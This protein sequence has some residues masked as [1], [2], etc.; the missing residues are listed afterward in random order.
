MRAS[1]ALLLPLLALSG[2][3]A[4]TGCSSDRMPPPRDQL[5]PED[6]WSRIPPSKEWLYATS[7][8][9]GP[10]KEECDH[11]FGW[12]KGEAACKAS[13]CEHGRELAEEWKTRCSSLEEPNVVDQTRQI[14]ADLAARAA[15][16]PTECGKRLEAIVR[17]GCGEDTTC[18]VT[19]QHWA[20]RCAKSEGTPMVM[21]ILQ[22]FLER[23]QEPGSGP[24]A[25]D[26]RTCD[27]LHA[28]VVA[29]GKCKDRFVCQEA[30]PGVETYRDRCESESE[31]PTIATAVTELTVLVGGGK[32]IKLIKVRAGSP[33]LKPADVPVTLGDGSGGV[34]Y[35]CEERAT[36]L[37][38]YLGSRKSCQ[39]G[40]MV[41]ARAFSTPRGVEVRVGTLDFPD[42]AWF[43]TRY[44]TILASGEVE[45][46]DKEAAGALA[47][48]LDK[49]AELAKSSG[50]VAEATRVLEKAVLTH[51]LAIKRSPALREVLA[52]RDE[53]FVPVLK[54]IARAKLATS[55]VRKL[56]P[57]DAAG[58]LERAKTRAFADL[59]EGGAVQIGAPGRGFTLQ[60]TVLLPRAMEA[61]LAV[62]KPAKIRKLDAK[63]VAA[64]KALGITAA[65]ACG[66]WEKKLQ[67]TKKSLVS[68]N[69]DLETCDEARHTAL[70]KSVDEARVA[71]ESAFH[72]LEAA[73]TTDV[74][75]TVALG[76]AADAA[77]CREP[78]W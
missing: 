73:R 8:F 31:L 72:D 30:I 15:E 4:L 25:L 78:W 55:K 2:L 46:R 50:G 13:L 42:D 65:Q 26:P 12:V 39:G 53:L 61:Y 22:R 40:K 6:E 43:S 14:Q 37:A 66:A 68:C 34:I 20:T 67:D 32:P 28:E 41:V 57:A 18:L 75:D 56:P 1:P 16:P 47:E 35:V 5:P 77:A 33:G 48:G 54:E 49:A 62:L 74:E 17:D 23:K 3:T 7:E 69:F 59:D 58:L 21:R 52:K 29:A 38:R 45:L 44:P 70:A 63:I 9:S 27:E 64:A 71:A 19:G 10:H 11:V 60:T 36:D 51:A 76:Q 24:V